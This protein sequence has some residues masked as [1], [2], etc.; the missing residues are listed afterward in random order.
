MGVLLRVS[1]KQSAQRG[2]ERIEAKGKQAKAAV[3]APLQGVRN[4]CQPVAELDDVVDRGQ[5]VNQRIDDTQQVELRYDEV[6]RKQQRLRPYHA[7]DDLAKAKAPLNAS[8]DERTDHAADAT[9]AEHEPDV[10]LTRTHLLGQ[11][12]Q[13]QRRSGVDEVHAP[14]QHRHVADQRLL[15]EP[16]QTFGNLGA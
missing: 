9:D 1:Q 6:Q 16:P 12:D 5:G 7:D 10:D 14:R 8:A 11:D 4:Q 3:D 15:P 2:A 13:Q